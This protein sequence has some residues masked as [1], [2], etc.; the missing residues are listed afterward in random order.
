MLLGM[1][2]LRTS[3]LVSL[4]VRD[5]DLTCGLIWIYEKGRRR[6]TLL[7][8]YVLCELMQKYLNMSRRKTGPLFL[9]KRNRRISQRSLQNIFRTIAD[10]TGIEKKLHAHLFRHTA[11][12]HLN[13]VAGIDVTQHVLGHAR[14]SNTLKYAHL[15]P[16]QY[17][18]YM[19]QHPYMKKEAS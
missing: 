19:R 7:M 11:A 3:S 10:Q 15:N 9:S 2:G 13:K 18:V 12:T 16:D 6:R 4:N 8:P 14:R 17:A 5:V 1:L